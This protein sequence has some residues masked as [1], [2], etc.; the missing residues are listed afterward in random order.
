MATPVCTVDATGIHKPSFQ[1]CFDYFVTKYQSIFGPDVYIEPDSQDGQ[2]LAIFAAALDD[3]NSMAVEIY[4]AFR[5]DYAQGAGLS[6]VVKINGISRKV[7]SYSNADIRIIGQAGSVIRDG[8]VS[9]QAGNQWSLPS[10]VEIP[11]SGE[12]TVPAICQTIGAIYAPPRTINQISTPT[13]GWQEAINETASSIGNPVESDVELRDRQTIST[14]I[15][16]IGP[17]DGLRGAVASLPGVS[18]FRIYENDSGVID[19]HGL[20]LYSLSAVVSGGLATEIAA[21]IAKKKSGGVR[22][23]GDTYQLVMDSSGVERRIYFS[24]P[25]KVPISWYIELQ[26]KAG[27]TI[28][29]QNA[30]RDALVDWTNEIII[31][32]T[33]V[34]PEARLPVQLYGSPR[35][36]TYRILTVAV[37]RDGLPPTYDDIN[38]AYQEEAYVTP[39]DVLFKVKPA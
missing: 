17:I 25:I 34:L 24:R 27:F 20:P 19:G 23:Y 6:S 38:L 26:S 37:A 11:S 4:N 21:T 16:S 8:V 10:V 12:I 7:P 32:G 2:T 30:I 36:K 39:D 9:D 18:R 28:D 15:P 3:A 1:E 14:M 13:L 35:E 22:T 33:I 5:P 29:V 31:G